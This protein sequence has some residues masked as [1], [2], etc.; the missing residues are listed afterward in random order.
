M[1]S[2]RRV[3]ACLLWSL[4]RNDVAIYKPPIISTTLETLIHIQQ[5]KQKRTIPYLL[6]RCF[7]AT[8]ASARSKPPITTVVGG[9]V[10]CIAYRNV[11]ASLQVDFYNQLGSYYTN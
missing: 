2:I 10:E 3:S 1:Y 4:T 9:N 6:R 11:S 7:N 8:L 5:K